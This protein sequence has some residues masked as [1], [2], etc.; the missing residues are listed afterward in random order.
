VQL[1]FGLEYFDISH[2]TL[3]R[4]FP[5]RFYFRL[6]EK[7]LKGGTSP[8]GVIFRSWKDFGEGFADPHDK[9]N[10][11]LH[12]IAHALKINVT[13]GDHFDLKFAFY[14]DNWLDIG[15]REFKKMHK[16]GEHFLRAY[17]GTNMH[18]FFAVCVEHFFEVP[19][20]FQA[21]LPS[22]YNHL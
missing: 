19:E 11:G 17:A 13:D 1:T 8:S 9:Y 16:A 5:E 4:I 21:P 2:F 7:Y 3:I 18:E 22:I 10:L 15:M 20:D 12:E 6:Y 14:L